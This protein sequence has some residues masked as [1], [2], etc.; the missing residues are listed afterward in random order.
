[1]KKPDFTLHQ[2]SYFLLIKN[3]NMQNLLCVDMARISPSIKISRKRNQCSQIQQGK[4]MEKKGNFY[5]SSK[6]SYNRFFFPFIPVL[7]KYA[8]IRQNSR[9]RSMDACYTC[10]PMVQLLYQHLVCHFFLTLLNHSSW[11]Y[12]SERERDRYNGKEREVG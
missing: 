10:F 1:M 9:L 5:R 6:V 7:I 11:K 2:V 3:E 12:I 8:D 4:Q